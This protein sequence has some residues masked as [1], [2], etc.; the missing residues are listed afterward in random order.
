MPKNEACAPWPHEPQP[1]AFG[2]VAVQVADW[3]ARGESACVQLCGWL[4][5]C[6]WLSLVY[7]KNK[8]TSYVTSYS[9]LLIILK[10]YPHSILSILYK[11]QL[12]CGSYCTCKT[13]RYVPQTWNKLR[14]RMY[15]A[16]V[17]L[18][19]CQSS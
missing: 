13:L 2:C 8:Y 19:V 5:G 12:N 11:Y 3:C 7:N 10:L 16:P 9:N 17:P 18:C 14:M 15:V 6:D 4:A 1:W